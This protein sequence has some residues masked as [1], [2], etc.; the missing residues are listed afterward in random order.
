MTNSLFYMFLASMLLLPYTVLGECTCDSRESSFDDRT[1]TLKYKL[2]ALG[3]ILGAG[4]VGVALPLVGKRVSVLRPENDVFFMIKAF[5]AGV[6]LATG[7]I[8]ILPDAFESLTSPCLPESPWGNF[9]FAGLVAMAASIGSLMVDT[10]ATGHYKKMHFRDG[11]NNNNSNSNNK[12]VDEERSGDHVGHVHVHTHATHGHAHGH[13]GGGGS[14]GGGDG[15]VE[16]SVLELVRHRVTAQVLEL[17]IV[18]HSVI[19]GI[20]LGTSQRLDTIKPLMVALCFHQFFEGMGLGGCISQ[21]EFKSRAM[22][23]MALFFSLTT[24]V[25]IAIGVAISGVYDESSPKALIIQGIF[26]SAAAGILIYMALVDLLATDFM[27]PRMQK[28]TRIQLG[29]HI[30]LLLG[31]GCMSVLAIWA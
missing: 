31:A 19:I 8:H 18:V 29:S 10:L 13:A 7:F 3:A 12:V 1:V 14:G 26:E 5:A 28:N 24:P 6:I 17:G 30:S 25:G 20:S 21:A 11:E 16:Q 9:P 15:E 4:G 2:G 22:A 27:H 23:T